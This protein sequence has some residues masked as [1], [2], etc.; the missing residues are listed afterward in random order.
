MNFAN[1]KI[2]SVFILAGIIYSKNSKFI[3]LNNNKILNVYNIKEN[4]I[5]TVSVKSNILTATID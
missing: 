3:K 4:N 5:A 2:S 1:I